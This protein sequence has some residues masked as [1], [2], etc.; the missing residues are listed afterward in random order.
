MKRIFATIAAACLIIAA[1]SLAQFPKP[2]GGSGGG[3]TT[4]T[5]DSPLS[6]T[7]GTVTC[8]T[9]SVTAP[10]LVLLET[11]TASGSATLDFACP[12]STYDQYVFE[13]ANVLPATDATRLFVRVSTDSGSSFDSGNNYGTSDWRWTVGGTAAGGSVGTSGIVIPATTELS[14]TAE[15]GLSGNL[16]FYNVN[17][18]VSHKHVVGSLFFQGTSTLQVGVSQIGVY[19]S[20]SAIT[21]VR[22]LMETG[23]VATGVIRCYGIAK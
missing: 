12:S 14:N 6:E 23:N 5:F 7:G 16:K 1:A 19:L 9:C 21:D 4:Y 20:T 11:E 17:S 22:F 8:P 2:G 18:T 10:A 15:E 3:G 13:L